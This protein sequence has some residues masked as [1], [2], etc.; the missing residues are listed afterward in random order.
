M[1]KNWREHKEE[2]FKE[3][4]RAKSAT[5]AASVK[6]TTQTSLTRFKTLDL[7]LAQALGN[8]K[9]AGSQAIRA[10][11]ETRQSIEKQ[12]SKNSDK[13]LPQNVHHQKSLSKDIFDDDDEKNKD[14][15]SLQE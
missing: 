3:L 9:S 12:N 14:S 7:N 8:K 13:G 10:G 6:G 2:N 5:K 1:G 11:S 4:I 15:G